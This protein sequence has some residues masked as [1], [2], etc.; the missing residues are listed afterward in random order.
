MNIFE[1]LWRISSKKEKLELN[2]MLIIGPVLEKGSFLNRLVYPDKIFLINESKKIV[3][4]EGI[5]KE[6]IS[7]NNNPYYK[8]VK[9]FNLT[10]P[11]WNS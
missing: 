2:H 7:I 6:I 11:K 3:V 8:K 10:N 5:P 4:S 9:M 1:H